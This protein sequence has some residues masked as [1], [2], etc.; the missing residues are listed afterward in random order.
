MTKLL[1]LQSIS[2]P[3]LKEVEKFIGD[4]IHPIRCHL[5][6]QSCEDF[7]KWEFICDAIYLRQHFLEDLPIDPMDISDVVDIPVIFAELVYNKD[8]Q[9]VRYMDFETYEDGYRTNCSFQATTYKI[10]ISSN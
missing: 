6:F 5:Q 8:D 1:V 3:E 10:P 2:D 7:K 4:E 9:Y